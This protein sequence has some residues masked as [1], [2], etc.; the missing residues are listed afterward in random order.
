METLR[1]IIMLVGLALIAAT[2]AGLWIWNHR[3]KLREAASELVKLDDVGNIKDALRAAAFATVTALER[4]EG[5]GTG[6][7][8]LASAVHE[9][10]QLVPE[11]YR[12]QFDALSI[13]S[14]VE[15]ALSEAKLKWAKNPAL[16]QRME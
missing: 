3:E 13:I 5:K 16:L 7:L 10:L 8:K 1:S 2:V 15:D 9:L 11:Q 6:A 4:Q 12:G 14:I